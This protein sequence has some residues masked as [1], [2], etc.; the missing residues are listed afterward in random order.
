MGKRVRVSAV[1]FTGAAAGIVTALPAAPAQATTAYQAW[2]T[3]S[4]KIH[5]HVQVCGHNQYGK[6]VCDYATKGITEGGWT[7]W[8]TPNWWWISHVAVWWNGHHAFSW[9]QCNVQSVSHSN[10]LAILLAS[11]N[12]THC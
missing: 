6:E 4:A 2:I 3:A 8:T 7:S 5:S 11:V 10:S 12:A 9:D 1:A